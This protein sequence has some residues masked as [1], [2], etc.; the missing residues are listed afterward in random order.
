MRL[1][2]ATAAGCPSNINTE[3]QSRSSNGC[4]A[5]PKSFHVVSVGREMFYSRK[6]PNQTA[7]IENVR[8]R[9]RGAWTQPIRQ[10]AC[11]T[12]R[13]RRRPFSAW[14]S[15]LCRSSLGI[16]RQ[17]RLRRRV[18]GWG[19]PLG[20]QPCW[21]TRPKTNF[22]VSVELPGTPHDLLCLAGRQIRVFAEC[23]P[24]T[25]LPPFCQSFGSAWLLAKIS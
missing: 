1:Y 18:F 3:A 5:T 20:G 6:Q 9:S 13:P 4:N 10:A 23:L 25:R 11:R 12:A 22:G 14:P 16:L 19:A 17:H 2:P 15:S 7:R 8:G 21:R 24:V